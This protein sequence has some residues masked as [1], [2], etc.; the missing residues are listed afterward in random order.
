MLQQI[1]QEF[2]GSQIT[3]R[4]FIHK[5]RDSRRNEYIIGFV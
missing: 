5:M 4:I 3:L 2:K 1:V